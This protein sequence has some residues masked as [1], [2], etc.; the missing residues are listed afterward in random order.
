MESR[1]V[2]RTATFVFYLGDRY[3]GTITVFVN[4]K[5]AADYKF[6]SAFPLAVLKVLA[7]AIEAHLHPPATVRMNQ[8]QVSPGLSGSTAPKQAN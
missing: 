7:P 5:A 8:N 4:G 6:T 3:F 1:A 2:N